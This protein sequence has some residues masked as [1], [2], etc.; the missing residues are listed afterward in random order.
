MWLSADTSLILVTLS[1]VNR[2]SSSQPYHTD[3][4]QEMFIP[5][6]KLVRTAGLDVWANGQSG[7]TKVP[8][9]C[10]E[11]AQGFRKRGWITPY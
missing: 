2:W 11:S 1:F 3:G 7:A 9:F 5:A 8:A 4:L 10:R 6:A